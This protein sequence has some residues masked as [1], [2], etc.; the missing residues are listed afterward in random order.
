[1]FTGVWTASETLGLTLGPGLYALVLALGGY[2]S[3]TGG[4]AACGRVVATGVQGS[5]T[6]P[7]YSQPRRLRTT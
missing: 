4:N 2:V 7:A 6:P 1:V 3:S 5:P